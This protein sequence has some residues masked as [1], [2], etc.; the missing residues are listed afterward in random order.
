MEQCELKHVHEKTVEKVKKDM[1]V[2]DELQDL[3]DFFKCLW[4]SDKSKNALCAISVRDV[5]L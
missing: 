4:R 5:C 1:P 2:E 3:A